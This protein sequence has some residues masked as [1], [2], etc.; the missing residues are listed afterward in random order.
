MK[1]AVCVLNSDYFGTTE[2]NGRNA[3]CIWGFGIAEFKSGIYCVIDPFQKA[4]PEQ[5]PWEIIRFRQLRF[6]S[7]SDNMLSLHTVAIIADGQWHLEIR[8]G[9]FIDVVNGILNRC[10]FFGIFI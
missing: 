7:Y 5:N 4:L 6:G 1:N 3:A 10:H 9:T 8:S 2:L